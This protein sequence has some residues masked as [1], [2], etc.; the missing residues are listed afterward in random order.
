MVG[1][2][3]PIDGPLYAGRVHLEVVC[4]GLHGV[5][6]EPKQEREA[7]MLRR[8][9]STPHRV[10]EFGQEQS[11]RADESGRSMFGVSRQLVDST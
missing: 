10:A 8:I 9:I 5:V 4:R 6:F 2:G 7:E 11:V 3:D 1:F